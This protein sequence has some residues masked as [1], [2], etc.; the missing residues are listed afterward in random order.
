MVHLVARFFE[1]FC[2][3][4]LTKHFDHSSSYF[5]KDYELKNIYEF[6]WDQSLLSL[7]TTEKMAL[8]S[9]KRKKNL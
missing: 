8:H 1:S 4:Y 6:T 9:Q 3:I 2:R 7:K 5:N